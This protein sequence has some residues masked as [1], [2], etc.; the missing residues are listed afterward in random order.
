MKRHSKISA[1]DGIA[2]VFWVSVN[3]I[4]GTRGTEEKRLDSQI[5]TL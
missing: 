4:M 3:S 2:R 1:I 5:Q